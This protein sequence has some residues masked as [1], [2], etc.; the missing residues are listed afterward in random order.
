LCIHFSYSN[1]AIDTSKVLMPT[2]ATLRG[3]SLLFI[4]HFFKIIFL[5]GFQMFIKLPKAYPPGTNPYRTHAAPKVNPRSISPMVKMS[6]SD[7]DQTAVV[8][9]VL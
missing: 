5:P 6:V 1:W 4:K 7:P 3:D 2:A 9:K 8:G